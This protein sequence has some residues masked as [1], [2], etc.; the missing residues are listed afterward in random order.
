MDEIVGTAAK[1]AEEQF[2]NQHVVPLIAEKGAEGSEE[3]EV[4]GSGTLIRIGPK[5]LIVTAGHVISAMDRATRMGMLLGFPQ[6]R[7]GI[8]NNTSDI[9]SLDGLLHGVLDEELDVGFF[10]LSDKVIEQ[11]DERRFLDLNSISTRA[12]RVDDRYVVFG[13]PSQ[14]GQYKAGILRYKKAFI[15]EDGPYAG[16]EPVL[17]VTAVK[18]IPELHI[19]VAWNGSEALEGISGASIWV[20]ERAVGNFWDPSREFK[21]VAVETDTL[22]GHWIRGTQ[23]RV[24]ARAIVQQFPDLKEEFT[25]YLK[26]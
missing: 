4:F 14:R 10:D 7:T 1:V 22:T 19:R 20:R 6:E 2:F 16:P 15:H 11:I 18:P 5:R 3:A 26:S 13:F 23:W 9:I 17:G 8:R 24:V 21:I 25:R 12:P